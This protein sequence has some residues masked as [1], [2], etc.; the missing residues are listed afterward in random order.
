MR[1]DLRRRHILHRHPFIRGPQPFGRALQIH[2]NNFVYKLRF[3]IGRSTQEA[4][5]PNERIYIAIPFRRHID[6]EFRNSE[7]QQSCRRRQQYLHSH[8]LFFAFRSFPIRSLRFVHAK[9]III[10]V[11]SIEINIHAMAFH[12]NS[13]NVSPH[14]A[15][16]LKTK[17]THFLLARDAC[18]CMRVCFLFSLF[19]SISFGRFNFYSFRSIV[20]KSLR[21]PDILLFLITHFFP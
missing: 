11:D 18:V 17:G 12:S 20:Y 7:F 16:K 5:C 3:L 6:I 2:S 21:P 15:I 13:I 4:L 14:Q 10:F 1:N 19:L 9:F 8:L